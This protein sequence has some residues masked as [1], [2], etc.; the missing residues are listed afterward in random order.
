MIDSLYITKSRIRRD[1]LSLFFSNPSRKYY[2]RELERLLGYS[3][4]SIRRELLKFKKDRI[5]LTE[6]AGNLLYYYLNKEHPL[7]EELKSIVS[8]TIGIEGALRQELS[9]VQNVEIAFIYGSYASGNDNA[10]S[11]IDV[12]I[13]GDPDVSA[14]NKKLSRLEKKLKRDIN[15]SIHTLEEYQKRKKEKRGFIMEL[16]KNPRIILVGDED[17]L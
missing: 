16:L 6:K 14:V 13:I 17:A 7:Y 2:L 1:L 5:F 11:D 9:R 4:G 8:K 10:E 12:M 3:A 15:I